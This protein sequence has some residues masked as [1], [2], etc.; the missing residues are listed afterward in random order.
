MRGSIFVTVKFTVIIMIIMVINTVI[1]TVF[2]FRDSSRW[3][4]DHRCSARPSTD[5]FGKNCNIRNSE[6]KRRVHEMLRKIGGDRPGVIAPPHLCKCPLIILPAPALL[7]VKDADVRSQCW[8]SCTLVE[9][10]SSVCNATLKRALPAALCY[11]C[12]IIRAWTIVLLTCLQ[13]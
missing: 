6:Q 1:N 3:S 9:Q 11:S 4:C 10:D 5:Y 2:S 7:A 8:F 12:V 13:P